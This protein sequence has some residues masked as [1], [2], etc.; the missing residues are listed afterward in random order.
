M[1]RESLLFLVVFLLILVGYSL[2]SLAS[3]RR[4]SQFII[5]R[6][7]GIITAVSSY[8][9]KELWNFSTGGPLVKSYST[10]NNKNNHANND[11]D[12]LVLSNVELS[13]LN[14]IQRDGLQELYPEA[15]S[16]LGATPFMTNDGTIFL[17]QK[18]ST[19][20]ALDP[21]TGII[22]NEAVELRGDNEIKI[23]EESKEEIDNGNCVDRLQI[24]RTEHTLE[25]HNGSIIRTLTI[26]HIRAFYQPCD[27]DNVNIDVLPL[28]TLAT[29]RLGDLLAFDSKG[30]HLW[31]F[32]LP[33]P[34][35]QVVYSLSGNFLRAIRP[36]AS[37][38]PLQRAPLS[39]TN[40][41]G[42]P[43]D[44][45]LGLPAGEV[46][47][48]ALPSPD[49]GKSIWYWISTISVCLT[50]AI[51]GLVILRYQRRTQIAHRKASIPFPLPAGISR[52]HSVP[53][54]NSTLR[55]R[56]EHK[57]L[58]KQLRD[59]LQQQQEQ[60]EQ[61]IEQAK[62]LQD[63]Q[64]Q[65][66]QQLQSQLLEHQQQ[67]AQLEA[68]QSQHKLL[69]VQHS[70]NPLVHSP[71]TEVAMPMPT[72]LSRYR[73]D[74]EEKERLG[75]GGF[76]TVFLAINKLD[77]VKYAVK[78]VCLTSG[79]SKEN[80]RVL[81]EVRYLALLDHP[82]II[83][84]FQSWV[85]E[86]EWDEWDECRIGSRLE[87]YE[88][89]SVD[90]GIDVEELSDL[91][92][93]SRSTIAP[94]A[95]IYDS[96]YEGDQ[97][98]YANGTESSESSSISIGFSTSAPGLDNEFKNETKLELTLENKRANDAIAK[99]VTRLK[100]GAQTGMDGTLERTSGST[101]N[102]ISGEDSHE[103]PVR[104]RKPILYIQMQYCHQGTLHNWLSR[105][106]RVVCVAEAIAI[107]R[108]AVQGVIHIHN[109]S[110]IHRD[111]KPPNILISADGIVKI[112]DFGL[113]TGGMEDT[114]SMPMSPSTAIVTG[115]HTTGVGSPLYCSPEQLKGER[116]DS[117][118]DIFALGV[119]LYEMFH[120]FSTQMERVTH[121]TQ[122]RDGLINDQ[123][124]E[125]FPEL[126][127]L[128]LKLVQL[129]PSQR[130]VAK[131][132]L[133]HPLLSLPSPLSFNYDN[134]NNNNNSNNINNSHNSH[135]N[136][137]HHNHHNSHNSHNNH[138]NIHYSQ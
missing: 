69:Q 79:N 78:K 59:L 74:F 2:S 52:H 1:R 128:T 132:I 17:S 115:S 83:R 56:E 98:A 47:P 138:H 120:I 10:S 112:G 53:H 106:D 14:S 19:R 61:H 12:N 119:I 101:S 92:E 111:L 122:L 51:W 105:P 6:V 41:K 108:Q 104:R 36:D 62:K 15:S 40:Y 11:E 13:L 24:V 73:A 134:N 88:D 29:S 45:S 27:P 7:D 109:F 107:F 46:K 57:E 135:N 72:T 75:E 81:R 8:T 30:T 94:R 100:V 99:G 55:L 23:T 33:V 38:E 5:P 3:A 68:Q 97:S 65:K 95:L 114:I 49:S 34:H 18:Q 102:P 28:P 110:V 4:E 136:H 82:N 127:D 124:R 87:D 103:K 31:E 90:S 37:T 26:A 93:S 96:S 91:E 77:G 43:Y 84:Y 66:E 130:P 16:V 42:T 118:V 25:T 22:I 67:L 129:D 21:L 125:M 137:N 123:T 71:S 76:G 54:S 117:K 48:L 32:Y 64:V 58:Q 126:A 89:E 116:Y 86:D 133:S 60:Q 85:E 63:L 50:F 70:Q 113:S 35:A 80:A 20:F 39:L 44:I 121:I 9:G 131:D